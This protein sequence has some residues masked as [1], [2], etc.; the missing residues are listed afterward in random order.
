M[1]DSK[2]IDLDFRP[3]GFFRGNERLIALVERLPE[4]LRS[5][6]DFAVQYE[7]DGEAMKAL[8]VSEESGLTE[9]QAALILARGAEN[10]AKSIPFW[11]EPVQLATLCTNAWTTMCHCV[12]GYSAISTGRGC[13]VVLESES[14]DE[15]EDEF[16]DGLPTMRQMIEILEAQL[17]KYGSGLVQDFVGKATH[18]TDYF[19]WDDNGNQWEFWVH[20]DVY[21]GLGEYYRKLWE[22][23]VEKKGA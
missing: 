19:A 2:T 13:R 10:E 17:W 4:D 5:E 1:S 12:D 15:G 9:K 22:E 14:G 21:P 11:G 7:W 16:S 18:W 3:S 8:L 23:R 20:S 6:F